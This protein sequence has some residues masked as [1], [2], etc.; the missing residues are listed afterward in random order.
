M[1]REGARSV[2]ARPLLLARELAVRLDHLLL[3]VREDRRV[4]DIFH[5]ELALA[6]G[7]AAQLR[8]VCRGKLESM[9]LPAKKFGTG[10]RLT[11][12][13]VVERHFAPK[14]ELVV[15]NL[16][17]DDGTLA[18]VDSADDSSCEETARKD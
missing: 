2:A 8:G 12:E 1:D 18:L 14:R 4:T 16:R 9:R 13:H 7:H 5:G 6:L 3:D 10:D 17:V 11:A 15:P